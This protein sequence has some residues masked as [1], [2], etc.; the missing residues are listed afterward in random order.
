MRTG[1]TA[2]KARLQASRA[3]NLRGKSMQSV[4]TLEVNTLYPLIRRNIHQDAA[5]AKIDAKALQG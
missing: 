5:S 4:L 2:G 1:T 3:K